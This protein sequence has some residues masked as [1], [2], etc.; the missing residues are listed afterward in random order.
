MEH[1]NRHRRWYEDLESF[2]RRV[3]TTVLFTDVV[4]STGRVCELGDR[5]WTD[6]AADAP[7]PVPRWAGPVRWARGRCRGRR[8]PGGVRRSHPRGG[9]RV[10]VPRRASATSASRSARASTRANASSRTAGSEASRSTSAPAWRAW[11][12]RGRSSCPPPCET[13]SPGGGLRFV[14]RGQHELRGV[15][16]QR[17]LFAA[18]WDESGA[19]HRGAPG[20]ARAAAGVTHRRQPGT[21]REHGRRGMMGSRVRDRAGPAGLPLAGAA[22]LERVAPARAVGRVLERLEPSGLAPRQEHRQPEVLLARA[23]GPP[24]LGPPSG[25]SSWGGRPRTSSGSL[26]SEVSVGT[27]CR[28]RTNRTETCIRTGS[29]GDFHALPRERHCS[30]SRDVSTSQHSS[31]PR[32]MGRPYAGVRARGTR[33]CAAPARG[34]RGAEPGSV[35]R[36]RPAWRRTRTPTR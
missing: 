35:P 2:S 28:Y 32:P 19:L 11:R 34:R 17:R 6:A 20:R 25:P 4:D 9:V 23:T 10:R 36:D 3:L 1:P 26:H 22:E 15:P 5:S 8:L 16:G 30:P 7:H 24:G 14:D 18:R 31:F 33:P 13:W 12:A 29:P 21:A 27:S